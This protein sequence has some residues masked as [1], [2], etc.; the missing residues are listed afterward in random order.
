MHPHHEPRHPP[1]AAAAVQALRGWLHT[2]VSR[3]ETSRSLAPE[4]ARTPAG[5]GAGE[6]R[7]FILALKPPGAA[8]TAPAK[9]P[10]RSSKKNTAPTVTVSGFCFCRR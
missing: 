2:N 4:A 9:A 6:A 7:R 5:P 8:W 3:A 1:A 10:G